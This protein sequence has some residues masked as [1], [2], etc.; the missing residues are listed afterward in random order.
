MVRGYGRGD[1]TSEHAIPTQYDILRLTEHPICLTM[2]AGYCAFRESPG[3]AAEQRFLRRHYYKPIDLGLTWRLKHC[4]WELSNSKQL[5]TKHGAD[6]IKLTKEWRESKKNC[7]ARSVLGD[8]G[9]G[10]GPD[11]RLVVYPE[12]RERFMPMEKSRCPIWLNGWSR[13]ANCQEELGAFF[14]PTDCTAACVTLLC[15]STNTGGRTEIFAKLDWIP[16]LTASTQ[17]SLT[18]MKRNPYYNEIWELIHAGNPASPLFSYPLGRQPTQSQSTRLY[19]RCWCW[20]GSRAGARP[21]V[22]APH[23]EP[24]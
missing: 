21:E 22:Y 12:R 6:A 18:N 8:C 5:K 16:Q 20:P 17:C 3:S 14:F 19:Q 15:Q 1:P 13:A 9:K 24:T 23:G 10:A 2:V 4:V 11:Q 7:K